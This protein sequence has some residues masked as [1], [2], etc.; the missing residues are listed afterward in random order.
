[1]CFELVAVVSRII[2]PALEEAIPPVTEV[3]RAVMVQVMELLT[4][5]DT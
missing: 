5:K 1:M 3:T 4:G 2:T